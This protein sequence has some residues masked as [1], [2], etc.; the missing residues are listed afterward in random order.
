M[1]ITT[2]NLNRVSLA[3]ESQAN[4]MLRW[5]TI[6]SCRQVDV[7]CRSNETAVS[8]FCM[9]R[10]LCSSTSIA[11]VNNSL[12]ALCTVS[13]LITFI[14]RKQSIFI[15]LQQLLQLIDLLNTRKS[16]KQ[17]NTILIER[18]HRDPGWI[19]DVNS[20]VS[21]QLIKTTRQ[22]LRWTKN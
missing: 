7:C 15:V 6:L 9:W 10:W 21:E 20:T 22:T 3:L 13:S 4:Y 14:P 5:L 1:T 19:M 18:D 8:S 16:Q 17:Y 11:I 2:E 12:R